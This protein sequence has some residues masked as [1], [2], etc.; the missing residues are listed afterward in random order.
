MVKSLI[1]KVDL[2][3]GFRW[4]ILYFID[5]I[6]IS[7]GLKF[8]DISGFLFSLH[9]P[10]SRYKMADSTFFNEGQIYQMLRQHHISV[11]RFFIIEDD[12]VELEYLD[13]EEGEKVVIK[14]I[15][16]DLWHKSEE[17]A[18]RILNFSK[19]TILN[20]VQELKNHLCRQNFKNIKVLICEF[21]SSQKVENLP[22]EALVSIKKSWACGMF[23]HIGLGGMQTESWGEVLKDPILNW[24]IGF[25]TPVEAMEQLKHHILGKVWLG[26]L[27]GHRAMMSEPELL[28]FLEKLW[29]LARTMLSAKI[30]FLELN[31]VVVSSDGLPT[32]LDGV[33]RKN[34][35]ETGRE[36]N[37][38]DFHENALLN[39]SSIAIAGVSIHKPAFGNKILANIL[40]SK[41]DNGNVVVIKPNCRNISG[42]PCYPSVGIL[43]EKPVDI[44]ILALPAEITVQMILQLLNQGGGA[45]YICIVPGGIGEAGDQNGYKR[46]IQHA[47]ETVRCTHGWS[48][49]LIGPNSLGMIN[50]SLDLSTL[51]ISRQKLPITF[52]PN[53]N[54]AIISQ[55][56]AFLIKCISEHKHLPLKYAFCIGNQ[57]DIRFSQLVDVCFSDPDISTIGVYAEGFHEDDGLRIAELSRQFSRQGKRIVVLKGGRTEKGSKAVEGHTGAISGEY[58]TQKTLFNVAGV[59]LA[60]NIVEFIS[61][62]KWLSF[63][64][65]F[66]FSNHVAFISNAGFSSVK[67]ADYLYQNLPRRDELFFPVTPNLNEELSKLLIKENLSSLVRISNPMDLTPMANEDV[68]SQVCGKFAESGARVIILSIVPQTDRIHHNSAKMI[69][70]FCTTLKAIQEEYQIFLGIIIEAGER[71]ERYRNR[72]SAHEIPVFSGLEE[73]LSIL[74]IS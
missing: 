46:K 39:P 62:L 38:P 21:M 14:G 70:K 73:M 65:G 1:G 24:P 61:T 19:G 16:D 17:G 49:I 31:P 26:N 71:Y 44:L 59:A 69:E 25:M 63:Y 40:S 56:G 52:Y 22:V 54:L 41:V 60:H 36:G 27:R 47:L 32:A 28:S 42:V 57:I 64:P 43:K 48:P 72:L 13:F 10:L 30:D 18:V 20:E 8:T 23:I 53:G 37:F 66:H 4:K 6:I 58:E 11:P 3:F 35:S 55:S 7:K 33:G 15:A 50:S 12:A 51:F 74:K 45:K 5:W 68:Y 34:Y 2:I 29:K 9:V 67:A